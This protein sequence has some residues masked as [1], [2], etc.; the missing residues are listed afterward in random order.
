MIDVFGVFLG[1][2]GIF[3]FIAYINRVSTSVLVSKRR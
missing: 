1:G 2:G 3:G